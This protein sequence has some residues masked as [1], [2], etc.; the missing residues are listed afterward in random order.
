MR[1]ALLLAV[2]FVGSC[3]KKFEELAPFPCAQDL[4]CPVGLS[5]DDGKCVEEVL[6][7][8]CVPYEED[9]CDVIDVSA[10]CIALSE[11][12]GFCA[13]T[14]NNDGN[15]GGTG[16]QRRCSAA[17]ACLVDPSAGDPCPPG[18][19]QSAQSGLCVPTAAPT[20][21]GQCT[22]NAACS[23][24]GD[25]SL[26]CVDQT[27][28]PRCLVDNQCSDVGRS[29]A[30]GATDANVPTRG[31]FGHCGSDGSCP[32]SATCHDDPS[33]ASR[34]CINRQEFGQPCVEEK[35][36][37]PD[38]TCRSYEITPCGARQRT[39]TALCQTNESCPA[40]SECN[41][42]LCIPLWLGCP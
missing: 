6:D 41:G 31:C 20:I 32:E 2:V 7:G 21:D 37:A 17:S 34:V 15:C 4:R 36:C 22:R 25:T 9:A 19:E 14:C 26:V 1:F 23:L 40:G 39:C 30:I 10:R 27:C 16:V 18:T 28:V 24:R 29:C 33:T 13:I 42:G 35:Q 11:T 3:A 12:V 5:C 38:F 8:F